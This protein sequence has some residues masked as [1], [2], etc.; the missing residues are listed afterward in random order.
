MQ[1]EALED[2]R[3]C[4]REE[5]RIAVKVVDVI[6]AAR[7]DPFGGIG[8]PEPLRNLGSDVWSRRI[9]QHDRLVYRFTD[10][11]IDLLQARHHY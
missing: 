5:R 11:S 9:T 8:K 2:L 6:E 10:A 4:V 3:Y 1:L 7:V